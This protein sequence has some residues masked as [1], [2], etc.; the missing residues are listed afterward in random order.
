MLIIMLEYRYVDT[1][2]NVSKAYRNIDNIR[3]M[4]VFL[5]H[6]GIEILILYK[7]MQVFLKHK[8]IEIV[9]L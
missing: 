5:K 7:G 1:H 4:Q 6:K 3:S 9:I 8:G 2:A